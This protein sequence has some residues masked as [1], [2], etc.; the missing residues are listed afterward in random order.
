MNTCEN[1]IVGCLIGTAVGDALGLPCEALSRS[2]QR[3]LFP[4]LHGHRLLFGRGMVSDDTEH[5]CL[6]AQALVLSAGDVPVFEQHLAH[7][8]RKWLLGLPAGVGLATL[9]ATLRLW[10]GFGP[11]RS[12]VFS[13]GN[14][15]A[16]R[17]AL[18]GVC[19]GHDDEQ[20][21]ALVRASTR[22]THTDPK[23]EH[24]A[25]AIALAGR[26]ASGA[27][28]VAPHAFLAE[29]RCLLGDEGQEFIALVEEAAQSADANQTSQAFADAIGAPRGFSG[30]VYQTVPGVLQCWFRHPEDFRAGVLEI[31]RCGGDTDTTAA[32]LGALIGARVGTAGIPSS[33]QS[34]LWEWPRSVTWIERLGKRLAAVVEQNVPQPR[35]SLPPLALAARNLFF[36]LVVLGHGLR[37]LLPPF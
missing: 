34:G 20:L 3:R 6:S 17:S 4:D 5:A 30:Y 9:K 36:L 25:L 33:W 29:L 31:V 18:L 8:L 27:K 23:A 7:E 11:A 12:G 16:M 35:L 1:A 14:G 32:I 10:L 21:R 13:A 2:R 37:R 24:G 19:Y 22:L 28:I 15:P 26:V